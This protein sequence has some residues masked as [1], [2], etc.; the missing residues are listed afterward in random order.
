MTKYTL[1]GLQADEQRAVCEAAPELRIETGEG[2]TPVTFQKEGQGLRVRC[3]NGVRTVSYTSRS[4]LMR[5]V[6]LLAE[7]DRL[8]SR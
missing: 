5:A 7:Q 4:A 2:G 8:A 1:I 3:V 6:G